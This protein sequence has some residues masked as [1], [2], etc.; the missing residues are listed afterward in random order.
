MSQTEPAR[1]HPT[2]IISA[3]AQ[4]AEDVEVGA[5]AII[6]GHVRVGPG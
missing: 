5:Y 1:R 2:A 3:E 4:L 6:E